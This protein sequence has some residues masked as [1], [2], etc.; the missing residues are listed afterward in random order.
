MH[1]SLSL[2]EKMKPSVTDLYGITPA[3][4]LYA[5]P[6]GWKHFN[7]LLNTLI[8]D[9]NNTTITEINT[10]HTCILF[11]GHGKDRSYRTI[12]SC[13]FAAKAAD[14]YLGELSKDDWKDCQAETQFQGSGM[15]HELASVLLTSAIQ[16]S[17]NKFL[18]MAPV[19][20]KVLTYLAR[21]GA[22]TRK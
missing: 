12:S 3:H 13:P 20:A 11:N 21:E 6:A 5:G 22:G 4:Y 1:S 10:V 15:S 8:S 18:I 14:I 17:L 19:T 9:V 7:L 16:N 2:L